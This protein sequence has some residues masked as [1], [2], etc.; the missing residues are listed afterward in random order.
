M[1]VT[2]LQLR[3]AKEL[4]V[5]GQ[6]RVARSEFR[7]ASFD[8]DFVALKDTRIALD[9]L[10]QRAGFALLGSAALAETPTA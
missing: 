1:L 2:G 3:I 4:D 9:R 10:H 6:H 8:S 5:I 7:E